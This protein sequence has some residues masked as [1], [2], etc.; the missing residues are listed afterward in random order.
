MNKL[1]TL[2]VIACSIMCS[3]HRCNEKRQKESNVMKGKLVVSAMCSHYIIQI[4]EG[5]VDSVKV[6]KEWKDESKNTTFTNAFSVANRCSFGTSNLKEGD[7]F[8]FTW[9]N[10]TD[11]DC[12]VCKAYYPTP[13]KWNAIEVVPAQKN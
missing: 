4:I 3:A 10:K 11:D 9:S 12:M 6:V 8:E 13:P 5:N 2:L 1:L 7:V